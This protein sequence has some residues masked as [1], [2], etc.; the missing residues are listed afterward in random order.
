MAGRRAGSSRFHDKVMGTKQ[1]CAARLWTSKNIKAGTTRAKLWYIDSAAQCFVSQVSVVV[2][3]ARL[4]SSGRHDLQR[5]CPASPHHFLTRGRQR[6]VEPDD[7]RDVPSLNFPPSFLTPWQYAVPVSVRPITLVNR[8]TV[9][10]ERRTFS[11][12]FTSFIPLMPFF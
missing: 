7:D 2:A 8:C 6:R 10:Q 4:T 1:G 5:A 12:Y 11:G 3:P 9:C